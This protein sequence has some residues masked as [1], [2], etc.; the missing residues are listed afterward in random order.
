MVK[1]RIITTALGLTLI[2]SIFL[3][4]LT[5]NSILNVLLC[6][7]GIIGRVCERL[8]ENWK[9]FRISRLIEGAQQA[10][11]VHPTT[12]GVAKLQNLI[13]ARRSINVLEFGYFIRNS[14]ISYRNCTRTFHYNEYVSPLI[15]LLLFC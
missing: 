1:T 13:D 2:S 3:F 7:V 5:N 4:F 10:I 8:I 9:Y 12:E 14:Q 11:E 15:K 6:S